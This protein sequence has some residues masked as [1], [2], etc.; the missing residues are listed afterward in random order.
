MSLN[1]LT[2]PLS[3]RQ[4]IEASAGTGKTFTLAALYVR[5]V[6]GHGRA[7]KGLQHRA[8][9]PLGPNRQLRPE[10]FKLRESTLQAGGGGSFAFLAEPS[11]KGLSSGRNCFGGNLLWLGFGGREV[12]GH[13]PCTGGFA[14]QW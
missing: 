10:V 11:L 13:Q 6:L 14:S 2:L 1:L 12:R 5:L 9:H 7:A 8:I 3:G 4:I